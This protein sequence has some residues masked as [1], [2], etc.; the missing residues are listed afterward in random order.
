MSL[1]M[2]QPTQLRVFERTSNDIGLPVIGDRIL[3]LGGGRF[4]EGNRLDVGFMAD[5]GGGAASG[6]MFSAST[7][8]GA[9]LYEVVTTQR[10]GVLNS[11]DGNYGN[12]ELGQAPGTNPPVFPLQDR[13]DWE[14]GAFDWYV[15]VAIS[16]TQVSGFELNK[17]FRLAP[18]HYGA[19]I[20]PF[21]GFRYIQIDDRTQ[22]DT[23]ERLDGAGAPLPFPTDITNVA[24]E[25]LFSENTDW[26]N[27]C[28]VGQL[29]VRIAKRMGRYSL[30]GDFRAFAGPNFQEY[31]LS[32]DSLEVNYGAGNVGIDNLPITERTNRN[33]V[34][35]HFTEVI[36]G[37]EIRTQAAAFVTRDIA[38][39]AG[40]EV[41]GFGRGVARSNLLKNDQ[42]FW[43]V[44]GSLG[45]QVLR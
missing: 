20:E 27:R 7:V 34:T 29:G 40:V 43:S 11:T 36:I 6:W 1:Y 32:L 23:Y 37:T 2:K 31:T 15:A 26:N 33:L 4:N 35:D 38:L 30:S 3:E 39:T 42:A 41:L 16:D 22:R 28:P 25:Q 13:N 44:G 8:G 18:L 24:I 14:S 12:N 17:S 19:T 45:V 21:V 9:T 10:I 5:A